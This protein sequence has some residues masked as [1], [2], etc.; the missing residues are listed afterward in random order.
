MEFYVANDMP[1]KAEAT[2]RTAVLVD[3]TNTFKIIALVQFQSRV[4]RKP[5]LAEQTLK[6]L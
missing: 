2:L 1:E 6:N 5:E 3:P 4:Q